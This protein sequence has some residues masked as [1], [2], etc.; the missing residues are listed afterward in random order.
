[1]DVLCL[2]KYDYFIIGAFLSLR[3]ILQG[4]K[5]YIS[6]YI[7]IY[8]YN[9]YIYIYSWSQKFTYTL[10]NLQNGDYFTKYEGS[11]KMHAIVYL[12]LTRIRFHI[13]DVYM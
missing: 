11:Y 9:I 6:F 2:I 8:I 13:K 4:K 1:M 12:V 10:Q 7:Y 5:F 3:K